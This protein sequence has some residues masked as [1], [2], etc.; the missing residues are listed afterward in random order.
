LDERR[1]SYDIMSILQDGGH[2]VG[3]LLPGLG[4]GVFFPNDRPITQ[5][6]ILVRKPKIYRVGR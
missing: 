3:N 5:R 1:Q 2:G 4:F 6:I